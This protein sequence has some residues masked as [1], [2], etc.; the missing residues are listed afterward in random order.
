MKAELGKNDSMSRGHRE[1]HGGCY[2]AGFGSRG[3]RHELSNS[4]SLEDRRGSNTD[5][6]IPSRGNSDLPL[7]LYQPNK[8][9]FRLLV[10][11]CLY[12][13]IVSH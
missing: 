3:S 13:Y 9:Q 10:S 2:A 12:I 1:R 8:M 6:F 11:P 4:D 7:S 5:L